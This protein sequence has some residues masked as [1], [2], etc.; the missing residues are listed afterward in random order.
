MINIG[1]RRELFIDDYLIDTDKTQARRVICPP[2]KRETA[3]VHDAPWEATGVV[4]HNIVRLPDGKYRMY[5][6]S[7]YNGL[8]PDGA[9]AMIRRIC[10][11][12]SEDDLPI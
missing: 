10:F 8:K 5:Y 2:V 6:K 12:E 4:Y 1:S 3:F 7:T 11:I 9:F